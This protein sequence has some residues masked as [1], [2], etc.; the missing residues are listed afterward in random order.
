MLLQCYDR[1]VRLEKEANLLGHRFTFLA[2]KN[3]CCHR[4]WTNLMLWDV[5]AAWYCLLGDYLEVTGRFCGYREIFARSCFW[6]S[7]K[8]TCFCAVMVK[9]KQ[10]RRKGLVCSFWGG[11]YIMQC[12]ISG[13]TFFFFTWVK[14][15]L[16]PFSWDYN[17]WNQNC[18]FHK[19]VILTATSIQDTPGCLFS[20][21]PDAVTQNQFFIILYREYPKASNKIQDFAFYYSENPR[22]SCKAAV[23]Q[24]S[25]LSSLCFPS[26]AAWSQ[27]GICYNGQWLFEIRQCTVGCTTL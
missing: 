19:C 16:F 6:G 25:P 11:E 10:D 9:I 8:K 2:L 27:C 21:V 7:K 17:S 20:W 18:I 13:V 14:P 1:S 5:T 23:L 15:A 4:G 26:S 12:S 3:H 22:G 24:F